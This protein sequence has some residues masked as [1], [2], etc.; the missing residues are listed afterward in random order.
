MVAMAVIP[1]RD[2]QV[3][4]AEIAANPNETPERRALAG[5]LTSAHIRRHQ[6]L[7]SDDLRK[8]IVEIAVNETDP[9]VRN[10]LAGIVG[11]QG[12][13]PEGLSKLLQLASPATA[14]NP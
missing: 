13:N 6:S 9:A 1:T 5:Q 12:P 4:L 11:A 14:P 7:L 2:V 8:Q 10:A 3:R